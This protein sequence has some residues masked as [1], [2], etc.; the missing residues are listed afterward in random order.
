MADPP[1]KRV[2]NGR[3]AEN[4]DTQRERGDPQEGKGVKRETRTH[5]YLTERSRRS[6]CEDPIS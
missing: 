4:G 3:D 5:S 6:N 2:A 1:L